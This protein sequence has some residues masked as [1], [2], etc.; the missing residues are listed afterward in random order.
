MK[1]KERE[2]SKLCFCRLERTLA[3]QPQLSVA[4]SPGV[5]L[6]CNLDFSATEVCVGVGGLQREKN[7]K[8]INL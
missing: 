6:I 2:K 1:G 3:V 5:G 8:T 4:F 7:D